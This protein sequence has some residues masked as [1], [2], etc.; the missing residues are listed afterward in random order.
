MDS[1]WTRLFQTTQ[2]ALN[3]IRRIASA[4]EI[5]EQ[6]TVLFGIAKAAALEPLGGEFHRVGLL[7]PLF[8]QLADGFLGPFRGDA[9]SVQLHSETRR[10]PVAAG[11]PV[12]RPLTGQGSVIEVPVFFE[13]SQDLTDDGIGKVLLAQPAFDFDSASGAAGEVT[14]GG[15][16]GPL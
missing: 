12:L 8:K 2:H 16:Q 3:H 1:F 10:A 11:Q 6:P 14:V 15:I 7:I 9:F 4:E 13:L 5:V